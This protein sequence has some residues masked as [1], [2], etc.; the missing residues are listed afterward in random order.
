MEMEREKM[1]SKTVLTALSA[2]GEAYAN[3]CKPICRELGMPQMAFDILM[4]LFNNPEHCTAKDISRFRGFKEN[5]ISVNVNKLVTEGYLLRQSD[6]E[7]R[8][9][10]RLICTEKAAA[11][12]LRGREIQG[13]F[14]HQ[15]QQ[16]LSAEE[17]R[18]YTH[19]METIAANAQR[20]LEQK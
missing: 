6:Q 10:V 12:A 18:I 20:L 9:K 11:I 19:C 1:D 5:V 8:R 3:A 16:G 17:L 14:L 13:Q 15:V 7:D 4:F 2:V